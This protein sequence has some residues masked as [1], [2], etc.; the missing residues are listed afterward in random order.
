M[1]T[2][3]PDMD[4]TKPAQVDPRK[5]LEA[6]EDFG[7][8]NVFASPALLE[9]VSRHGVQHGVKWPTVRRILTAG[10]PVPAATLE[11]MHQMLCAGAE[12]FTPYG[13]TE[14]LPVA[15]IGSRM[16]LGQTRRQTERAGQ[17]GAPAAG[18][19]RD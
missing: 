12:I 19:W 8:T 3:V 16:I 7:V 6:I 5:I 11:R 14:A 9:T 13:A 4:F 1:T 17:G 2:I 15:S 10:A 18:R